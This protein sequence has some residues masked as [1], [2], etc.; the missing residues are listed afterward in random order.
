MSPPSVTAQN[1]DDA[2]EASL[3]EQLA[4]LRFLLPYMWRSDRPGFKL[5]IIASIAVIL[6]GQIATVFAPFLFADAINTLD[7]EAAVLDSAIALIGGYALLRL[8]S[9][10]FPQLREFLFS[11]VGQTAQREVATDVFRHLHRL[12]LRFHLERRTGGLSRV[13]ERGIR[14]I[15]FLFRFLLFNI[16]PT[17]LLLIIVCITFAVRYNLLLSGIALV[18]VVGY[19]WFTVA[20]TEWRLQFRREMNRKDQLASTRSVDALLNYETVKYF[21]NEHW[22]SG[23]YDHALTDYQDAAVKSQNS[24]AVVNIGQSLIINLGLFAALALTA[25]QVAA[26]TLG[27]GEI[28][29]VSLIMMQLYQPLNILGFAYR[30]IKQSL[31]DME[32]MFDLLHIGPEIADAPDAKPLAVSGAAVGFEDVHFSYDPDREILRGVS[33]RAA[34][35]EKIAVVGP[36]GAGKSTI[37]RLLY[38]F[39]DV[40]AGRVTIDGQDVRG[41]T[42]DS[43]RAAIGMVPQDTVLFNDTIAYNIRYGRPG[44]SDAEVEEAARLAQIHSFVESLPKGYDTLV[45]ERGLKLSG[46]EKQRVAIARTILKD[47]A[48]LILDE[49]TSALDTATE[50]EILTAFKSVSAGRTTITVAHRLSTVVDADRILVMEGGRIIEEGT[51]DDLLDQGGLYA[52]LWRQQSETGETASAEAAE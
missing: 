15:D 12:S 24:L 31:I 9:A 46:G 1:L 50:R 34:P 29:A 30:E 39:Y 35:G 7:V 17:I 13:I 52:A 5:R 43:L 14:S 2:K 51:H 10:I 8:L 18:T 21:G 28:T 44:A 41:V 33:F 4:S 27:I 42:Q 19:F 48:L 25:R 26:G 20:S 3:K 38:R 37:A 16:G 36:S 11:E 40:T 23:R 49:A 6:I 47:P 45:G 32:R 22:E